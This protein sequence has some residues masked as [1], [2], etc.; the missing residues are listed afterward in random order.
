MVIVL[1]VA[2]SLTSK[3]TYIPP[4]VAK[5]N[6][7]YEWGQVY[8]MEKKRLYEQSLCIDT[9]LEEHVLR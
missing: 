7:N 4:T 6:V 9:H 1:C 5:Q 8:L 2:V 3:S